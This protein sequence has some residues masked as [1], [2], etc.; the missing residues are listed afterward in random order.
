MEN[1]NFDYEKKR[2]EFVTKAKEQFELYPNLTVFSDNDDSAKI[3]VGDTLA[4]K[5]GNNGEDLI[6]VLLDT[7]EDIEYYKGV[8]DIS[9]SGGR[10]V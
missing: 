5:Y 4:I 1:R 3:T 6:I 7:H 9:N 8:L 10:C 2:I